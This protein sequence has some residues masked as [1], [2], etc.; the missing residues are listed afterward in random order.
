MTI[1]KVQVP[2]LPAIDFAE[3]ALFFDVDGT[4]L[5]IASEPHGVKSAPSLVAN[6]ER[7]SR[8]TNGALAFISGRTLENLDAI[9]APLKLTTVACHGAE[10]RAPDGTIMRAEGLTPETKDWL[11]DIATVDRGIMVED[12]HNSIAFH[13]RRVPHCEDVIIDAVHEHIGELKRKGLN[14]LH[15][16]CVLEIKPSGINKGAGLRRLMNYA[17]FAGRQPIFAG[18]DRTDEDVFA[19]LPEF[20]GHGISVGRTMTGADF[21]VSQPRDIRHWLGQLAEQ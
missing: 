11:I 6:L 9:F 19:I 2:A 14:V 3:N 7:L 5:D 20:G 18:D 17:P 8:R 12:K 4:L 10:F 16:K 13:Y 21:M 1:A 15:G